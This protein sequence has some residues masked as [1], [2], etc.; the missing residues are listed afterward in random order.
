MPD[1][2]V[3]LPL[4]THLRRAR[5]L[6]DREFAGPLD[7]DRLARVAGLSKY[8][9]LRCFTE[10][11][12][13]TPVQYLAERRVERAQDLLRSTNLTVTEI[14]HLVGYTSLG[15][16]SSRFR[17]LVGV[18]PSSYQ[19]R[20][21]GSGTPRIPGCYVLMH[22]L[23]DRSRNSGEARDAATGLD[24]SNDTAATDDKAPK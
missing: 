21:A 6:I 9:F 19:A 5:D 14:C 3:P 10:T 20:Y 22:G 4:L 1:V 11:Y 24:S 13:R 2:T 23:S 7:L 12:G 18:S 8:H 15:S 17:E 16:F